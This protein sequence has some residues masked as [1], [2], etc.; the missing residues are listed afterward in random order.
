M[1]IGRALPALAIPVA[2]VLTSPYCRTRHT[3]F[4]IFSH[5]YARQVDSLSSACHGDAAFR[6]A[7][8]TALERLITEMPR[9]NSNTALITHRCNI[10]AVAAV[11]IKTCTKPFGPADALVFKPDGAGRTE[12]SGCIPSSFW[13]AYA[14]LPPQ[15][16]DGNAAAP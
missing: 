15:P 9:R 7:Q 10:E 16:I 5:D 3:A 8:V 4:L 13:L 12:F 14:H 1:A 11:N 2:T 6:N